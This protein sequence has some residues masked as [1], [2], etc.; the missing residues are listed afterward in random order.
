MQNTPQKSIISRII[1]A[2]TTGL[3]TEI[4]ETQ[5]ML[6]QSPIC[7]S[8]LFLCDI[9]KITDAHAGLVLQFGHLFLVR[10][11]Q[12]LEFRLENLFEFFVGVGVHVTVESQRSLC[13]LNF[14]LL[15]QV[16]WRFGKEVEAN[17]EQHW[18]CE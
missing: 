9:T 14:I 15:H 4:N 11:L 8:N 7:D 12:S 5:V 3:Q 18:K 6:I 1:I 16:V 10:Q 17:K 2:I 13:L